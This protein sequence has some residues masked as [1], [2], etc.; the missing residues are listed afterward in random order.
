MS[1]NVGAVYYFIMSIII[2][3][4]ANT[5]VIPTDVFTKGLSLSAIGLLGYL[6]S[7]PYG[8]KITKKDLIAEL[9]QTTPHGRDAIN[10]MF[11]ELEEAGYFHKICK[12]E[13]GKFVYDYEVYFESITEKPLAVEPLAENQATNINNIN[14][15]NN[16]I[17]N[18]SNILNN[19]ININKIKINNI[20][21]RQKQFENEVLEFKNQYSEDMLRAFINYWSEMNKTKTKMLFELKQTFEINRRLI[22]WSKNS[23][24]NGLDY[25]KT[26]V[27]QNNIQ[28]IKTN[29]ITVL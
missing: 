13:A 29:K 22:T 9:Q 19:N 12:R 8:F 1:R 10:R 20:L 4:K 18:N 11:N 24:K 2:N 27:N 21:E 16:N 17:D 6:F 28:T 14:I 26:N 23:Y 7:K 3:K 5:T 25:N 15:I